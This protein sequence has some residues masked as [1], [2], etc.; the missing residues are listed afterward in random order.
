M[1]AALDLDQVLREIDDDVRAKRASGDLPAGLERDLDLLF[2]RFS[3]TPAVGDDLGGAIEA[4]E[5]SAFVDVEVPTASR[6][7]LVSPLKRT[8]KKLMAWYLRYLAQQVSAFSAAVVTSLRLL[9]RRV[10]VL[11]AAA[12]DPARLRAE[13]GRSGRVA[14]SPHEG[15]AIEVLAGVAGRV[16]VGEAGDGALLRRLV[17]AGLDAYGVDPVLAVDD[18]ATAGLEVR[19]DE[20]LGH[21]RGVAEGALGALVLQRVVDVAAV[22]SQ[23]EL[24]DRA[25]AALADGGRLVVLGTS[26]GAWARSVDVVEADLAPGRPLHGATWVAL[27]ERR[28]FLSVVCH[29]GP[30]AGGLQPTGDAAVDANLARIEVALFGPASYAV[31]ATRH[32]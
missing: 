9:G 24:A 29:E 32:R 15:V 2:D 22:G 4:A 23:L 6:L 7:P 19:G 26:P 13:V 16:L 1:S 18:V 20:L 31:T 3:P 11:E 14:A 28:G 27:L 21:L 12:P 17:D 10:E 25:A 5:R 30:P 8:L